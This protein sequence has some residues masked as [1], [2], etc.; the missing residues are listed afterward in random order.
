[1]IANGTYNTVILIGQYN[2]QPTY[3][4]LS[5]QRY[6]CKHCRKTTVAQTNLTKD[7]CTIS[8]PVKVLILKE[9]AKVQS[10]SLI[11]EHLNVSTHTVMRQL[12][13]YSYQYNRQ[14]KSLPEHLA[15]DEF[16]SVKSVTAAMSCILMD[17]Y[18]HTVVDVLENR[19]QAYLTDYFM[20]FSGA[21]R[22]KVKTITMDMNGAFKKFLPRLFPNAI[23]IIDR[24]HIV[25]LMTRA[26]NQYRVQV[27]NKLK[28]RRYRRDANKFKRYWKL[29]LKDWN[30]LKY[31]DYTKYALF[32]WK[33]NE[34]D[35]VGYL[36]SKDDTLA[37][38]YHFIQQLMESV[39][40]HSYHDFIQILEETK[41]YTFPKKVRTT[42]N[43][44]FSYRYEIENSLKYTLSNG[45][46]EGTNNKIK[47][48]KRSGSGYRNFYHLR[49]RILLSTEM[50]KIKNEEYRLLIF[51][52]EEAAKKYNTEYEETL[53]SNQNVA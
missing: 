33:T 25:Q 30:E 23:V 47:N 43:T 6:L 3:L 45:C 35:I 51:S 37:L 46:V 41:K 8:S 18:K 53:K 52:E 36:L 31:E 38:C 32:D 29:I 19:T 11:A 48:I 44:L 10:M 28:S 4:K 2:F 13:A 9:L 7:H 20:R 14:P 40:S 39:K 27:M 15:I 21:D 22:L 17:N 5:K 16:K 24:F 26:L 50:N 12:K 1:M 42:F 34:K 49:T